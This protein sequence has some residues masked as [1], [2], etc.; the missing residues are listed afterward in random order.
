MLSF[1]ITLIL[2]INPITRDCKCDGREL[3]GKVKV[4]EANADFRVQVKSLDPDLLVIL[5]DVPQK[6]GQ[7]KFIESGVPDFT[8]QFVD[9]DPDFTIRYV[10][11]NPGVNRAPWSIFNQD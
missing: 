4:V 7:W 9:V 6:C 8:I 11:F 3:W 10:K 5:S 1:I 2:L